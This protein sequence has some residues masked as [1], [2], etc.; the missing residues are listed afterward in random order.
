MSSPSNDPGYIS[1]ARRKQEHVESQIPSEWRLTSQFLPN[2]F[3]GN[4]VDVPR[5]C[6]LLTAREVDI[7]EKRDVK[8]LLGELRAGR[9]SAKEAVLAFS[10]VHYPVPV[11]G[12]RTS[13]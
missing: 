8:G 13:C 9:L 3:T 7:T 5:K 2:E 10:K 4:V 6:G 12:R 11:C 1:V